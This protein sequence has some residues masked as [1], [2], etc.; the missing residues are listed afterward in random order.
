M[1]GAPHDLNTLPADP[2]ADPALAL[3]LRGDHAE[4]IEDGVAQLE[5]R[6]A[7]VRERPMRRSV[8]V[9]ALA[10]MEAEPM[11]AA[12]A[13]VVAR[14]AAGRGEARAVLEELAL[15]PTMFEEL[16][17]AVREAGYARARAA[18]LD[19]VAVMF[20]GRRPET[21]PT[22][23]EAFSGN[24]HLEAP[25]GVRRAAAR[26]TDRDT[27]DRLLHDRDHRVITLL[28]DNPRLVERDAV[29]I[30]ARRPTRPEV[31]EVVARHRRWSSRYAVRKALACNPYTPAPIARRLLP[32]LMRQ[33][34]AFIVANGVLAEE[35]RGEA[36]ALLAKGPGGAAFAAGET[37][38]AEAAA[39]L[40]AAFAAETGLEDADL[41]PD[42][43]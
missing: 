7:S 8:V 11:V 42:D 17:Y 23:D 36:L 21:N 43:G 10:P 1:R 35:L 18:G 4:A 41:E 24:D 32:V 29:T 12:L 34:L 3:G 40:A 39:A 31:L 6:L 13:F 38:A 26:A 5:R 20:L 16:P 27:L 14:A 9:G 25:L 28:L 33:D 2:A 37:G 19:T 22:V 15:E 30:A